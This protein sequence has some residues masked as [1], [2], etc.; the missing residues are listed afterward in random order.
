MPLSQGHRQGK[1]IQG[2]IDGAQAQL[3]EQKVNP[4]VQGD[5]GISCLCKIRQ[6]FHNDADMLKM[7]YE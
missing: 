7:F 2:L 3:W 1:N 6:R 5:Y 4:A